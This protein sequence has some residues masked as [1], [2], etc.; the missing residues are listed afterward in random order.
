M[1]TILFEETLKRDIPLVIVEVWYNILTHD[2]SHFFGF[3]FPE[4]IFAH[5][6]GVAISYR[7]PAI[8]HQKIPLKIAG[9]LQKENNK[10]KLKKMFD[11]FVQT[12]PIIHKKNSNL[13]PTKEV[14][15]CIKEI[16][17]AID[18]WAKG[19]SGDII[20]FWLPVW[21][22]NHKEKSGV[23]LYSDEVLARAEKSRKECDKIFDEAGDIV[24][25]YLAQLAQLLNLPA[26]STRFL[27]LS[28]INES[29]TTD[30]NNILKKWEARSQGYAYIGG[31]LV[32]PAEFQKTI[33]KKR[34]IIK[35]EKTENI[36]QISGVSAYNGNVKGKAKIILTRAQFQKLLPGDVLVASMTTPMYYSIMEKAAAFVTDEGGLLCHAAIVSREMKKPCIISTKI[37]T[38]VLNDEDF[39]EVDADEGVIKIL[40]KAI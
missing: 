10:E 2:L 29:S 3:Q 6:N 8:F 30:T 23:S 9:W 33:E 17:R 40:K 32:S 13:Q 27:L 38:K 11:D 18:F 4:V 21:N 15:Q 22:H 20:A 5:Q 19:I 24:Y 28:E 1:K 12:Y 39:I 34:Y 7:I 14:A 35:E 16:N 36:Q 31:M 26:E 25:Y 37:A